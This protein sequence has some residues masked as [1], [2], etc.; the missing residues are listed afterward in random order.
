MQWLNYLRCAEW[1][2]QTTFSYAPTSPSETTYQAYFT[3]GAVMGGVVMTSV[4]IGSAS[5][6][7]QSLDAEKEVRRARMDKVGPS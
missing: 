7:L 5:T 3:L 6:A 4:I 2:L 1:S